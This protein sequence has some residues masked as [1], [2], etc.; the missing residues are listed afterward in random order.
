M[1]TDYSMLSSR[2]LIWIA[3]TSSQDTNLGYTI[4]PVS[5]IGLLYQAAGT[6]HPVDSE[7]KL[8]TF[9]NI[10]A[11]ENNHNDIVTVHILLQAFCEKYI[12]ENPSTDIRSSCEWM[13]SSTSTIFHQIEQVQKEILESIGTDWQPTRSKRGLI[14]MVGRVA[15]LLFGVCSDEDADFLYG[16][17]SELGLTSTSTLNLIAA[18]TR[19]VRATISDFNATIAPILQNRRSSD[20]IIA[21]LY[22]KIGRTDAVMSELQT[23]EM[24]VEQAIVINLLL[25]QQ[26]F[27]V[28]KL[29]HIVNSAIHGQIHPNLMSNQEYKQHLREIQLNLPHELNLPFPTEKFSMTKLIQISQVSAILVEKTL[30][31]I[32]KIPLIN[33]NVFKA[34]RVIPFPL[35]QQGDIYSMYTSVEPVLALSTNREYFISLS[36]KQL[37]ECKYVDDNFYCNQIAPMYTATNKICGLKPLLGQSDLSA[38]CHVKYIK[39]VNPIFSR[40]SN[41]NT[42]LYVAINENIAIKCSNG[43]P[44]N[45]FLNGTGQLTLNPECSAYTKQTILIPSRIFTKNVTQTLYTPIEEKYV[46]KSALLTQQQHTIESFNFS[47]S[48]NLDSLKSLEQ[49]S[50]SLL[51][52]ENEINA[53]NAED[54]H[55]MNSEWY[56][57][58]PLIIVSTILITSLLAAYFI[59]KYKSRKPVIY[60]PQDVV[61]ETSI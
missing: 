1:S 43:D 57:I 59:F 20:L 47:E 36:E 25:T 15:K 45:V 56:L 35:I 12:K 16:K 5:N 3:N 37:E 54:N 9:V 33:V 24:L 11:F 29:L 21:R 18:Q 44:L 10:S 22:D 51:D 32:Q 26:A 46:K 58:I 28:Q 8:V 2:V 55:I 48:I 61:A 14:N 42:W 49:H 38:Y 53:L 40:L 4:Q 52:I 41:S 34:Y 17:I 27:G 23:R 39:I 31:F 60:H 6:L 19:V 7:Y 30:I 50:K 13:E